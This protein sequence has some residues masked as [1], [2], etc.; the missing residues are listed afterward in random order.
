MII[1][2]VAIL[3][4]CYIIGQLIGETLGRLLHIDAN[5]GGV[6]FA[7]LLLIICNQW[8]EKNGLLTQ[9]IDDGVMFWSKMYIPVIVAMSATQNVTVALSSGWIALLAGVVPVVVCFMLM[10]FFS[11]IVMKNALETPNNSQITE[12]VLE[13]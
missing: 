2:G 10:P 11:K 12:G 1:R 9:D 13:N 4:G 7:M 3:A 5:V 6:G 8:M